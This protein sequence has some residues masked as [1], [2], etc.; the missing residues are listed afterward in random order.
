MNGNFFEGF[1]FPLYAISALSKLLLPSCPPPQF[2]QSYIPVMFEVFLAYEITLDCLLVTES[3][4][5]RMYLYALSAW[6]GFSVLSITVGQTGELP[7]E[8]SLVN[9]SFVSGPFT[10]LFFINHFLIPD[11]GLFS[12]SFFFLI[13]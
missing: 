1:L 8:G 4:R 11:L 5:L 13:S 2:F 9:N 6:V 3:W 12:C 7:A 10:S